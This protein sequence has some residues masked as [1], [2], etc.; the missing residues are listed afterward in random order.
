[1]LFYNKT[2]FSKAG[3]TPPTT[4]DQLAADAEALKAKGV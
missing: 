3:I 4:W 2:L 1:M